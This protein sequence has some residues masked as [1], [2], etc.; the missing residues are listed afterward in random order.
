[1]FIIPMAGKS[2]RFFDA[3]YTIPKFQLPINNTTVFSMAL[4]SFE[5]YFYDD[6]FLFIMYDDKNIYN[7][8]N[9]EIEK[10]NIRNYAVKILNNYTAG[11]AET[12]HIGIKDYRDDMPLYIFNIDTFINKFEKPIFINEC[13]GFL[14]VFHGKGEHWSFIEPLN[15]KE[16][17]KTT[18][19]IKI[20]DYCSNGLYFF[21][22]KKIFEKA[23]S[24]LKKTNNELYIAPMYNFLIQEDYKIF[25]RLIDINKLLFCGTPQEYE[26]LIT[27]KNFF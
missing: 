5:K 12:V 15:E 20:S 23:Y 16:V 10:L 25:Y 6:F 22:N 14:D 1:M 3:G 8:I 13:D 11:Q 24:C 18:E 4:K 2:K 27:T 7:F 19:K 26:K 17:K 21:K 9:K